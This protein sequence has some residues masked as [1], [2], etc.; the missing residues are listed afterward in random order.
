MGFDKGMRKITTTETDLITKDSC[1]A[2]VGKLGNE[3]TS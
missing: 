2:K 1:F 3:L